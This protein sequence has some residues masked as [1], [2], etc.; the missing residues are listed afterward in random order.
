MNEITNILLEDV[1]RERRESELFQSDENDQSSS[2]VEKENMTLLTSAGPNN[3]IT[4]I[5]VDFT[6][7]H[8]EE[9]PPLTHQNMS[10]RKKLLTTKI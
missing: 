6:L 5:L 10:F 2:H 1:I 9:L 3:E 7:E 8:R 4:K